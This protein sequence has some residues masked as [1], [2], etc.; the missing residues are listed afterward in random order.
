MQRKLAFNMPILLLLDAEVHL[1]FDVKVLLNHRSTAP[2]YWQFVKSTAHRGQRAVKSALN[3][4]F[5]RVKS[6]PS[7][8]GRG[9][10][11]SIDWCIMQANL[12]NF[13]VNSFG[14]FFLSQYPTLENDV[15]Q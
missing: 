13:L 15:S 9:A 1:Y 3:P 11:V 14:F 6:P 8:G 12:H 7:P 2:V 5:G 4:G 10:G